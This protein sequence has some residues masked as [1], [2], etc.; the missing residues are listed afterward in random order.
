[1][2]AIQ[3]KHLG[4][5]GPRRILMTGQRGGIVGRRL[6]FARA[7]LH[8]P[9]MAVG[10]QDAHRLHAFLIVAADRRE[11]QEVEIALRWRDAEHDIGRD[12]RRAQIER[13]AGLVRHPIGIDR[14]QG[15][16]ALAD[17]VDGQFGH[18]HDLRRAVEAFGMALGAEQ[19][20]LPVIATEGLQPIE[21]RLAVVQHRGGGVERQRAI[22][23]DSRVE[24]ALPRFIIHQEHVVGEDLAEG[25]LVIGRLR[26]RVG[27]AGG[28][29]ETHAAFPK[30]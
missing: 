24:P 2:D 29:E 30:R 26:L 14:D 21:D 3:V 18:A 16:E 1:M 27:G 20:D 12:D 5:A 23:N 8:R 6:R 19:A 11:D 17:D 7:A 13:G 22:G 15:I 10:G 28:R 4:I 25:K 9:H